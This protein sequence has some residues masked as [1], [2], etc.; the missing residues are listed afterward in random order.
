MTRKE[1]IR[2]NQ[3][4]EQLHCIAHQYHCFG[5]TIESIIQQLE[6]KVR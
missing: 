6:D 5:Q 3:Q 2:I 1:Y 4:L